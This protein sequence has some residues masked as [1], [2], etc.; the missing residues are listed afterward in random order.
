[1]TD[2]Q[3]NISSGARI[4]AVAAGKAM[5]AFRFQPL[6]SG[7]SGQFFIKSFT[8]ALASAVAS[9]FGLFYQ[10]ANANTGT[11]NQSALPYK[12]GPQRQDVGT[13]GNPPIIV[14]SWTLDPVLVVTNPIRRVTF[15]AT[16]GAS[17]TF[18]FGERG[19][20]VGTNYPFISQ[21]VLVNLGAGISADIDVN[22]DGGFAF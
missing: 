15:P 22:M 21:L 6:S 20:A 16:L 5:W 3:T 8:V 17:A 9:E 1:M 13:F 12:T 18:D 2:M 7:D 19:F 10:N 14:K 11:V 4:S